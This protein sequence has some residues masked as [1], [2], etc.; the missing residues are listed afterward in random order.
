MTEDS[1]LDYD[2]DDHDEPKGGLNGQAIGLVVVSILL[3]VSLFFTYK[4]YNDF[5]T[6]KSADK[7]KTA[8][9]DSL[10][11]LSSSLK[12][13]VTSKST[14][15]EELV[16]K[17][18]Q[19]EDQLNK[20]EDRRDSV[21][22][23]LNNSRY[24]ERR[25]RVEAGRLKKLYEN[26]Q[27][28]ADSLQ[29]LYDEISAGSGSTLTEYRK[30]IEQLTTERNG[31]ASQ[32]QT[33][34]AELSKLKNDTK[35]AL[36]ALTVRAI[37][38]EL[39]RSKFSPSTKAKNTDRV[40]LSFQLTRAPAANENIMVKLF[41]ATNKEIPLKP[42]YRNNIGKPTPTNQQLVVEPDSDAR[43]KFSRGNYSIRLFLTNV[44][45]GINNQSIGIA[46]F[47]LR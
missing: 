32:N 31:L 28:K 37:P 1:N 8:A 20:A 29:K 11:G 47:S 3:V 18:F 21:Q 23:L 40:Q 14:E 34:Q 15:N 9:V 5:K 25:Y 43:R 27:D 16:K 38:G 44:D 45:Q 4:Y 24:R 26:A 7:Q 33:M 17:K 13:S 35:N 10:K 46:E 22:K 36:F 2:I 42:T 6:V 12:D 39:R 30:Q 41:D 19:L